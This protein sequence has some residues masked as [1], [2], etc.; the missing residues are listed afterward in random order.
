MWINGV[1]NRCIGNIVAQGGGNMVAQGGG[2]AIVPVANGVINT[3]GGDRCVRVA[4][5]VCGRG[6]RTGPL[7][8]WRGA[9]HPRT[10][11]PPPDSRGS[12]APRLRPPRAA[13]WNQINRNGG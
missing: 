12:A 7:P 13:C 3:N 8:A 4:L 10:V 6:R 2:N 9:A 1:C 5:R 11:L